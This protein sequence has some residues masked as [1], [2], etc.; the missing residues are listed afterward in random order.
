V[1]VV[2]TVAPFGV[3]LGGLKL[4][5]DSRGSPEQAKVT[6]GLNPASGAGVT[7]RLV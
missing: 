2:A 6:V 3:R 5:V 7:A 1:S 4:Q